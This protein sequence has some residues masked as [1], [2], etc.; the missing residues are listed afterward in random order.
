MAFTFIWSFLKSNR[1][2]FIYLIG[3]FLLSN[4]TVLGTSYLK[5]SKHRPSGPM[6][7]I[8]RNVRLSVCLSVCPSVSSLLR[9]RLNVFLPPLPEVGCPIF[10]ESRNPWGKVMEITDLRF[11]HF[12]LEI[13]KN[14][15][16]KKVFFVAD[17][18]LENMVKPHF[19]MD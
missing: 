1:N 4:N 5:F 14:R 16:A 12:C 10:L 9:Y 19:P 8:S 6:L 15:R 13:I 18:A 3:Q 2:L 17:F 11:E 7:S